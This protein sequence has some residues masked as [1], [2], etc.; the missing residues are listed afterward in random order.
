MIDNTIL[1]P[2]DAEI[3]YQHHRRETAT[4]AAICCA[5]IVLFLIGEMCEEAMLLWQQRLE[6]LKATLINQ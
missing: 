4:H 5:C 3:Q 2:S 6:A 1:S